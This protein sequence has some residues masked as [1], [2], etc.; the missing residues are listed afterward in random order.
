MS[1]H[2][3]L[4]SLSRVFPFLAAACFPPLHLSW[5]IFSYSTSLASASHFLFPSSAE[6]SR[7]AKGS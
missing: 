4:P 5:T 7:K 1:L 2:L 3:A 6:V